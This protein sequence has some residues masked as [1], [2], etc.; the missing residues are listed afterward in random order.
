[1]CCYAH[2]A[3]RI[4]KGGV[5]IN[6]VINLPFG[7]TNNHT[8]LGNK[9]KLIQGIIAKIDWR[10]KEAKSPLLPLFL[11]VCTAP[12][13]ATKITPVSPTDLLK[14]KRASGVCCKPVVIA[15]GCSQCIVA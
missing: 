5:S 2:Y 11:H 7:P 9:A 3:H 6:I 14:R 1:M 10:E 12:S 4:G 13:T 15:S 8:G